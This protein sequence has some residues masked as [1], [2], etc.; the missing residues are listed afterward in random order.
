MASGHEETKEPE[1]VKGLY[2]TF[3]EMKQKTNKQD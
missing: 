2:D 1:I 3:E